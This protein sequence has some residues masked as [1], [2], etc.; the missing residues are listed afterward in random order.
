MSY[1]RRWYAYYIQKEP[2]CQGVDR[3]KTTAF[4]RRES[5]L[6]AKQ[7]AEDAV[8]Q[9]HAENDPKLPGG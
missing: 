6:E 3:E 5:G 1:I 8:P 4:G 2:R 9:N 7:V